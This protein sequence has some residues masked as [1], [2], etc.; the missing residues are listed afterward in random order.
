MT[1]R[2]YATAAAAVAWFGVLL[3]GCLSVALSLENGRSVMDGLILFFGFFTVTTNI[4]VCLALTLPLLA[5]GSGAARFFADSFSVAGI[6][7][8]IAFVALSYHFLLRN[9]WNPRGA[10]LLADVLLHYVV[11]A[12]FVVYWFVYWRRGLLK[13]AHPFYWSVYPTLYFVYVLVRGEVI[14]TYPYGFIDVAAIGYQ[15]TLVNAVALLFAVLVLGF[16]VV[17]LDSAARRPKSG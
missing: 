9:V 14:G 6:A 10:Q 13:W 4:L 16:T 1:A 15:R 3:Q 11:P 5:R 12:L 7:T 8:N 17:W 2:Q